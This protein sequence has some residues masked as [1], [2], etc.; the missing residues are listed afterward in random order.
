MFVSI[1]PSVLPPVFSNWRDDFVN[2]GVLVV[3]PH[4]EARL[5]Y[6]ALLNPSW[7][8]IDVISDA[9]NRGIHFYIAIQRQDLQLFNTPKEQ[10]PNRPEFYKPAFRD[11][12]LVYEDA[13]QFCD[14]WEQEVRLIFA[15]PHARIYLFRG[16]LLWRL[17][18]EFGPPQLFQAV[19][20]GPSPS[21]TAWGQYDEIQ[22]PSLVIDGANR[23]E[24]PIL[25]GHA[26]RTQ[27]YLWPPKD[28]IDDLICWAGEW[29]EE[30][31]AWFQERLYAIRAGA[32]PMTKSD[33]EEQRHRRNDALHQKASFNSAF[34]LFS[35][36]SEGSWNG[37]AI[38]EISYPLSNIGFSL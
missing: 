25:L 6:R 9:I 37:K 15:R 23:Y 21:A 13:T 14:I 30:A 26:H 17:A 3:N 31:E 19:T 4:Q 33:W 8:I 11:R 12:P 10:L 27:R 24:L 22:G 29:D 34:T 35:G 28:C 1:V 7:S 36:S 16:D 38:R 5:R 18:R 20:D 2:H 32:D